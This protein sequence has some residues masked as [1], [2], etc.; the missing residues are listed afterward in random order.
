MSDSHTAVQSQGVQIPCEPRDIDEGIREIRAGNVE[1]GL[2]IL[3]M[4]TKEW[5]G[6]ASLNKYCQGLIMVGNYDEAI[7]FSSEAI[8]TYNSV[9][10]YVHRGIC[11]WLKGEYEEARTAWEAGQHLSQYRDMAGG[12]ECP[13]LV[14][15]TSLIRSDNSKLYKNRLLLAYEG[16]RKIYWPA[17]LARYVLGKAGIDDP[18]AEIEDRERRIVEQNPDSAA[19]ERL[20]YQHNAILTF[21]RGII[22]LEN[23]NLEEFREA[24]RTCAAFQKCENCP[25]W[26]IAHDMVNKNIYMHS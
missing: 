11:D 12:L 24:I 23:N 6:I 4:R 18:L 25:E 8:K 5:R 7:A 21:Y 14:Y 13:L 22:A 9:T 26:W 17:H 19:D 20:S 10:F 16:C 15:G 2:S 1:H 3:K